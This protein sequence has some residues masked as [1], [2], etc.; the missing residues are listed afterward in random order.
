MPRGAPKKT[1]CKRGHLRTPENVYASRRCKLCAL[2]NK[3]R[4]PKVSKV[5][6]W[7]KK[8]F[9]PDRRDTR[10]CS[11]RCRDNVYYHEHLEQERK[12]GRDKHRRWK[13]QVLEHYGCFC[14]CPGCSVV[15][16]EWLSVEHIEGSGKKHRDSLHQHLY[17]WLIRNNFP[18][19]F[20]IFC[21]NC[22]CAKGFFGECPHTRTQNAKGIRNPNSE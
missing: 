21:Y 17:G 1:T 19:G 6:E 4:R 12:R 5:C 13:Q 14:H 15:E 22:N 18:E 2:E 8:K 7:C 3:Q 20:T 10:M 9:Y 11:K 16:P